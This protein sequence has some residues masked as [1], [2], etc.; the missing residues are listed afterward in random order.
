MMFVIFPIW[1]LEKK[2]IL[3]ILDEHNSKESEEVN[4]KLENIDGETDNLDITFVKMADPRYARKWGVTKLPAIVYFRKRFP[5]IY[6]GK[7]LFSISRRNYEYFQFPITAFLNNSPLTRW[8]TQG[9]RRVGL[10]AQEQ[11]PSTGTEHLHVYA[12]RDH[13]LVCHVHRLLVVLFPV[14][15]SGAHAAS[16]TSVIK[17][18]NVIGK[19]RKERKSWDSWIV[20]AARM[21]VVVVVDPTRFT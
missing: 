9:T 17:E 11:I 6:R 10:A 21:C 13:S 16:E 8:S 5:S 1:L 14:R 15:T 19:E 20:A 2:I 4:E 7:T 12:D 18:K 3:I